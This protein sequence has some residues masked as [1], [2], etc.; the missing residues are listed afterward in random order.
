[1]DEPTAVLE[2]QQ[3]NVAL[4]LVT[5]VVVLV[6]ASPLLALVAGWAWRVFRWAAWGS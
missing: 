6:G 1:M 2:V 5:G 3:R 4:E